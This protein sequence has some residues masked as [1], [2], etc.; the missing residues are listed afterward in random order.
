[1]LKNKSIR[2]KIRVFRVCPEMPYLKMFNDINNNYH[3]FKQIQDTYERE[4]FFFPKGWL[5]SNYS[6]EYIVENVVYG[7]IV[8]QSIWAS[9]NNKFSILLSDFLDCILIEQINKFKP[10]IIFFNTGALYRCQRNLRNRIRDNCSSVRL[11]TGSWGDELPLGETYESYLGDLDIIFACTLGYFNDI[12]NEKLKVEYLP[13]AFNEYIN[14]KKNNQKK[15]DVCFIG[16]TGY[17]EPDHSERFSK[18]DKI[19]ELLESSNINFIL[20]T[21]EKNLQIQSLIIRNIKLNFILYKLPIFIL[22]IFNKLILFNGLKNI[23]SNLIIL[24]KYKFNYFNFKFIYLNKDKIM[25]FLEK[26][27]LTRKY[28]KYSKKPILN[29]NEY[30][31]TLSV[32][33]IVLNIHRNEFNDFGNIRCFEATGVGSCLLTDRASEISNLFEEG[34]DF[35]GFNSAEECLNK[36]KILLADENLLQSISIN[37]QNRTNSYHLQVHRDK[38]IID[39]FKNTLSKKQKIF[40]YEKVFTYDLR[41]NPLSYDYIFFLQYCYIYSINNKC[42][43]KIKLVIPFFEDKNITMDWNNEEIQLRK[44]R[45]I[46][47]LNSYFPEF[48]YSEEYKRGITDTIKIHHATY[49]FYVNKD[50]KKIK[51]LNARKDSCIYVENWLINNNIKKYVTFTIRYSKVSEERNTNIENIISL[52]KKIEELNYNI[53]VICDTNFVNKE[54]INKNF[55]LFN[56]ASL[57]FDLRLAIY[58]KA[59]M[60][61]FNNNGPCVAAT[62]DNKVKHILSKITVSTIPHCTREF[63]EQQGYK[64][65]ETPSYT[66]NSKWLWEDEDV[67]LLYRTFISLSKI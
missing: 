24:K 31:K 4:N 50:Y 25:P 22:K 34:K 6:E 44:Y 63:I 2:E 8:S 16:T 64:F 18:L 11:I 65:N 48:K 53:I 12:K 67:N 42:N 59:S 52:S 40:I 56:E 36:I 13:S 26:V 5:Q 43:V 29:A 3:S 27:K 51:Q 1:M 45:I 58:E 32:S 62:L 38:V 17:L 60:N 23:I 57:D 46:N 21:K 10:D 41:Y 49:Y 7:D 19:F 15:Y 61:F 28:K 35:V 39:A 20:V 47:Q 14:F 9:E 33:K 55:I 30:Y 37:G 66:H 54:F